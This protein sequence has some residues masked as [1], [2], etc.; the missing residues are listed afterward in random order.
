MRTSSSTRRFLSYQ[1]RQRNVASRF[2]IA[3]ARPSKLRKKKDK[4]RCASGRG[5]EGKCGRC[6]SPFC[7]SHQR[8]NL[9]QHVDKNSALLSERTEEKSLKLYAAISQRNI[10]GLATCGNVSGDT[11]CAAVSCE[12]DLRWSSFAATIRRRTKLEPRLVN[13]IAVQLCHESSTYRSR[14][15]GTATGR[16]IRG[17]T[18]DAAENSDAES[19]RRAIFDILSNVPIQLQIEVPTTRELKLAALSA[20]NLRT[21]ID[22]CV[23]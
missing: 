18:R 8:N 12:D 19:A 17:A 11:E 22:A 7:C 16:L 14:K 20:R 5:A 6:A 13:E 23:A 3:A 15:G 1:V 2:S 10:R 21:V 9:S 4:N